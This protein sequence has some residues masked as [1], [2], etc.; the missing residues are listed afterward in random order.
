MNLFFHIALKLKPHIWPIP[1]TL[2]LIFFTTSCHRNSGSTGDARNVAMVMALEEADTPLTAMVWLRDGDDAYQTVLLTGNKNRSV[3]TA[4][5]PSLLLATPASILNITS[6]TDEIV[7]CDC[8]KLDTN[9]SESVCPASI[10]SVPRQHLL[11]STQTVPAA[12]NEIRINADADSSTATIDLF[13]FEISE[14]DMQKLVALDEYAVVT[15]T[16]GP[17]VFIRYE[18]A[19]QLCGDEKPTE[20]HGYSVFNINRM[21]F[22]SPLKDEELSQIRHA[23]Q[24]IAYD[25]IAN[26]T[27]FSH[28]SADDL[29]L[30]GIH[31]VFVNGVGFSLEYEFEARSK[32][33]ESQI[34]W[35]EYTRQIS[36]QARKIPDELAPFALAPPVVRNLVAADT[37]SIGGWTLISG[38]Q[39][40]I[41]KAIATLF[42]AEEDAATALSLPEEK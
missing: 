24:Q 15:G 38:M 39:E 27:G 20:T 41:Q 12:E 21:E 33:D 18:R 22:E 28:L 29:Q 19:F 36:I 7:L 17:Y 40:S 30:T 11:L 13:P 23:E 26:T 42:E 37:V 16:V 5:H 4:T 2:L 3:A 10:Q 1:L 31:P 35:R 34:N 25:S 9:D 14:S 6:Q 32:L 8:S